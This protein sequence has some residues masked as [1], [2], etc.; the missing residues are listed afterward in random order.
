MLT[1]FNK[2]LSNKTDRLGKLFESDPK[3]E[4]SILRKRFSK[5][6]YLFLKG[7]LKKK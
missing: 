7:L 3:E 2:D 4:M 1:A 5:D 6:G